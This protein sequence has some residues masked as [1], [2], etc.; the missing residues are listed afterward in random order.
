MW[1]DLL[2]IYLL[3][4]L[5]TLA[6]FVV[7]VFRAWVEHKNYRIMWK[8]LEWRRTAETVGRI[9]KAEKSLFT[10]TEG[11][12]ELYDMLCELFQCKRE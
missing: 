5:V 3:N 9:L 7:L 11:G 8:E 12:E 10:K 1:L 6:M 2:S 4:L